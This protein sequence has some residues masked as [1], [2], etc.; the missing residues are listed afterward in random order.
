MLE[1]L[2]SGYTDFCHVSLL[3]HEHLE[4]PLYKV[5][6]SKTFTLHNEVKECWRGLSRS[7]YIGFYSRQFLAEKAK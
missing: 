7:H 2:L 4:S 3:T 6:S 1:V 5:D